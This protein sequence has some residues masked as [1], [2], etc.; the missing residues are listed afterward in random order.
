[1]AGKLAAR[2]LQRTFGFWRTFEDTAGRGANTKAI[3]AAL[4]SFTNRGGECFPSR[5]RIVE[6]TGIAGPNVSRVMQRR[7]APAGYIVLVEPAQRGRAAVWLLPDVRA[8]VIRSMD[9]H[10]PRL[11]M[12]W[13]RRRGDG[14][15]GAAH[16]VQTHPDGAQTGTPLRPE[17]IPQR[18]GTDTPILFPKNPTKNPIGVSPRQ[19]GPRS[20]RVRSLKDLLGS[21]RADLED[22]VKGSDS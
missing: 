11:G 20:G 6:V 7:L 9:P 15:S 1:M 13:E 22:R 18:A 3:Y 8:A 2:H 14:S 4:A 5:R 16:G 12:E 21:A 10:D 19:D 17:L